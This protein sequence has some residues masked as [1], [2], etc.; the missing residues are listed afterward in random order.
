VA[1]LCYTHV[2]ACGA[3]NLSTDVTALAQMPM[4]AKFMIKK[5]DK[6]L[7]SRAFFADKKRVFDRPSKTRMASSIGEAPPCHP[8][9]TASVFHS[10][11]RYPLSLPLCSFYYSFCEAQTNSSAPRACLTRP[12]HP[13]TMRCPVP[14]PSSICRSNAT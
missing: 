5:K 12:V 3:S 1:L 4:D 8:R 7:I 6:R 14:L 2:V 11:S 10:R 13:S 9:S